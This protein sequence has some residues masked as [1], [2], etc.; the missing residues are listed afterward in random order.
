M[1]TLLLLLITLPAMV[2][3]RISGSQIPTGP[4][5]LNGR[6]TMKAVIQED[7]AKIYL[8]SAH[9]FSQ[10]SRFEDALDMYQKV[11]EI[12]PGND[13]AYISC[14]GMNFELGRV[15]EGLKAIELD[16]SFKEYARTD[17]DFKSLYDDEDFRNLTK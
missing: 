5:N 14:M 12:Q 11:I 13:Q 8:D 16:P 9:Y 2:F 15:E 3:S 7:S 17:E 4:D 10:Q 6:I 1:K